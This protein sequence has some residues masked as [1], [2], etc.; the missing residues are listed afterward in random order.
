MSDNVSLAEILLC[1]ATSAL[2][3]SKESTLKLNRLA[4]GDDGGDSLGEEVSISEGRRML[5]LFIVQ[6]MFTR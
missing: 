5:K 6:W 2:I 3:D 4:G 1:V